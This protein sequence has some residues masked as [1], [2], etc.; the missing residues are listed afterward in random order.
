VSTYRTVDG[1]MIDT[2]AR[3]AYGSEAGVVTIYEAN[4][5]LA[6]LG[7]VLPRGLLIALPDAAPAP[8]QRPIRLWG[9]RDAG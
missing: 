3:R 9:G 2:L 4:P 5:R 8:V 1:D 7:P 6:A